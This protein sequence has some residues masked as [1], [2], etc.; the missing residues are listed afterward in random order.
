MALVAAGFQRGVGTGPYNVGSGSATTV[1]QAA[2]AIVAA[3][4]SRSTIQVGGQFRVGDIRYAVAD[5]E[6]AAASFRYRPRV[7]FVEGIRR[8]VA[9]VADEG[10]VADRA[11]A[12]ARELARRGLLKTT[13]A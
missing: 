1:R 10:P 2:E 4:G 5:L 13:R 8:L 12:A 3:A 11:D 7:P 9:W 6:R